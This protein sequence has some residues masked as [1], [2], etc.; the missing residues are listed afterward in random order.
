MGVDEPRGGSLSAEFGVPP[1]SVLNAR[2]GW[3]QE[4]KNAWIGLGIKSE[5]GRGENPQGGQ[6]RTPFGAKGGEPRDA[7]KRR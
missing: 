5:L 2:E 1:F 3:W 7:D 4:R 6:A